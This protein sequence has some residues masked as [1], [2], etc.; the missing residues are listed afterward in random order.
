MPPLMV[1][2]NRHFAK[3]KHSNRRL[4]YV[5]EIEGGMSKKKGSKKQREAR[6]I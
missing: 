3:R 1:G 5:R 2:V 6:K 4:F